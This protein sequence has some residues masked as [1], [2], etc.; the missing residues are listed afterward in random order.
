MSPIYTQDF[1]YKNNNIIFLT[2]LGLEMIYFVV[3]TGKTPIPL[4]TPPPIFVG[5]GPS[6][7]LLRCICVASDCFSK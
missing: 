5:Q 3:I 1:T 2:E 4:F 6:L 7:I